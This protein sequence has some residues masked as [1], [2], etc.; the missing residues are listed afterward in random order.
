MKKTLL[1]FLVLI[2]TTSITFAAEEECAIKSD[3]APVL[4]EYI[5]N[6]KKA[7]EEISKIAK[8]I[9]SKEKDKTSNLNPLN[10]QWISNFRAFLLTT[11]S[12]IFNFESYFSYFKYWAIFPISNEIPNEVK[13]D[14]RLLDNETDALK[15]YLNT[16][17]KNNLNNIVIDDICSSINLWVECNLPTKASAWDLIWLLIKNHENVMNM[18]RNVIMWEASII[19]EAFTLIPE[20]FEEELKKYYS[21]AEYSTCSLEDWWFFDRIE[22]AFEK[23]TS[24][25]LVAKDWIQKWKDAID[26]LQWKDTS[27]WK[28]ADLEKKLLMNELWRQWVH[29]DGQSNMLSALE[30]FNQQWLSTNSNFAYNTFNNTWNNL[31]NWLKRL[32]D[33]TIWDFLEKPEVK[34][35][36]TVDIEATLKAQT[37]S[38][39][40]IEI[41]E[42]I[43]TMY[44]ELSQMEAESETYASTLIARIIKSHFDILK[45][46]DIL[47][48]SCEKAVQ[49]CLKQD[50]SKG[51]C[52]KCN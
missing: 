7:R 22:T 38:T 39:N 45:S 23:V 33:D 44:F 20:W 29:W 4:K 50:P 35:E 36:K 2:I 43:N 48:E 14:Y 16:I 32:K 12:K 18:Y 52:W 1:T 13:R 21:Q 37:N 46:I 8:D 31:V 11:Y 27:K 6:N 19:W 47:S 25:H 30:K 49:V 17:G 26:L 3:T 24:L 10:A 42:R 40:I 41:K 9:K 15:R 34:K 51:D 5:K 28:Y